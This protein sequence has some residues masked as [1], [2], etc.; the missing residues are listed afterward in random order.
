M[1]CRDLPPH[2]TP[3]CLPERAHAKILATRLESPHSRSHRNKTSIHS[4]LAGCYL[5]RVH[6]SNN[7][8]ATLSNSTKSNV[9][10]TLLPFLAT[11]SKQQA[12]KL[13]VAST[14]LVRHRCWCGPGFSSHF[15]VRSAVQPRLTSPRSCLGLVVLP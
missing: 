14:M 6:T 3:G 8:E 10:S 4:Q 7:V 15:Q 9:I 11:V 5:K 2:D 12:K 1:S 13:P